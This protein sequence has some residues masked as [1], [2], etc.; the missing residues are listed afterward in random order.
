MRLLTIALVA[1][2][3]AAGPVAAQFSWV[4][5]YTWDGT[6]LE[7]TIQGSR[8]VFSDPFVLR[9][10]VMWVPTLDKW[11]VGFATPTST[12]T[13][14]IWRGIGAEPEPW[15]RTLASAVHVGANFWWVDRPFPIEG[16]FY[17]QVKLQEWNW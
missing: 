7:P 8:V 10:D 12:F 16:G 11:S 9:N 14:L 3:L 6:H 17:Y 1:L 2:L 5:A 15:I 4:G 13:D